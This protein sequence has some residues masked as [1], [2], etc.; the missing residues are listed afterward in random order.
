[1]TDSV[2]GGRSEFAERVPRDSVAIASFLVCRSTPVEPVGAALSPV[3]R[4]FGTT[5]ID[6]GTEPYRR[7]IRPPRS[8][9]PRA[10]GSPRQSHGHPGHR[11][12]R[13]TAHLEG[14]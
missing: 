7:V 8:L 5:P 2:L 9:G 10:D 12:G 4:R 11:V 1:M 14:G 13:Y 6:L 3:S